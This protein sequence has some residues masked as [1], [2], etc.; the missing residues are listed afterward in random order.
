VTHGPGEWLGQH[1]PGQRWSLVSGRAPD[2]EDQLITESVAEIE[3]E[4]LDSAFDRDPDERTGIDH[5]LEDVEGWDGDPLSLAEIAHTSIHGWDEDSNYDR[6]LQAAA[7]NI[8]TADVEALRAERDLYAGRLL[9]I[10]NG[11]E[12]RERQL[13]QF[14]DNLYNQMGVVPTDY[15]NGARL[16][17]AINETRE[18]L[19]NHS[20][21]AAHLE[22]GDDFVDA[23]NGLMDS[24]NQAIAQQIT[25]ARDPGRALME[26]HNGT[27]GASGR[28]GGMPSLNSQQNY[29]YR[30]QSSRSSGRGHGRDLAEERS[31]WG[32]EATEQDFFNSVWD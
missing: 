32:D 10:A 19:T 29:G 25:S 20:F 27:P 13:Q 6:P 14:S 1:V 16:M 26:W 3:R 22:H 31:G 28:G 17:G 7:E 23:F 4:L 8:L 2:P 15:D 21:R 5:D 18:D 30:G 24:G 12:M 11:P 9:E